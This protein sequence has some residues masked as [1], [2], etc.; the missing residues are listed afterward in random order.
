MRSHDQLMTSSGTTICSWNI[1]RLNNNNETHKTPLNNTSR[2]L[3]LD[4]GWPRKVLPVPATPLVPQKGVESL[5]ATPTLSTPSENSDEIIIN[6]T[7]Q[8]GVEL[9]LTT[10]THTPRTLTCPY[11]ATKHYSYRLPMH[12][13]PNKLFLVPPTQSSALLQLVIGYNDNG[14]GTL[15]WLPKQGNNN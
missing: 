9:T 3:P 11:K 8:G 14:R 4:S 7:P 1:T 10:P 5:K 15:H 12:S 13:K 2:P 6:C